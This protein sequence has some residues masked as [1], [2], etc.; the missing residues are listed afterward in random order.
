MASYASDSRD[1]LGTLRLESQEGDIVC[2]VVVGEFDLANAASI[3]QEAEGVIRAGNHLIVDLSEA[4][5]VDSSVIAALFSVAKHAMARRRIAV[6]QLGTA[7]IVERALEVSCIERV[8][9]R[10]DTRS[11]AHRAIRDL[12]P[13]LVRMP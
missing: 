2:L 3:E 5:F 1:C 10:A 9:P 13:G 6:L 7:A 4:T 11:N 8:L 12:E